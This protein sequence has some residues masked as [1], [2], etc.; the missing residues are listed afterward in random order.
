MTRSIA[1]VFAGIVAAAVPAS[2]QAHVYGVPDAGFAGGFAHP[3]GGLDHV[4]AMVAVGLWAA[5]LG[6]PAMALVP[7]AFVV[8]MAVGG[9]A[10]M[11]GFDVAFVETAI[12]LSLVG[13]GAFVALRL[14]MPLLLALVATGAFAFFHGHAHGSAA[15]GEAPWL[16]ALGFATA[17]ALLHGAGLAIGL[18]LRRSE[19]LAPALARAG[20]SGIAA[21]GVA[22]LI[23]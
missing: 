16:Y 8:A 7:A 13:F 21:V 4:L 18:G 22:L 1:F 12:A 17:T 20:G 2:V 3:F 23:L 19:R 9:L 6:G 5:S 15:T 11:A 10:G 14:R